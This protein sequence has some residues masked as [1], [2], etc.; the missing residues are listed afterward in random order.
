MKR[1]Y[2]RK[3]KP[4]YSTEYKLMY[5]LKTDPATWLLKCTCK[6]E[7]EAKKFVNILENVS[8]RYEQLKVE[9]VTICEIV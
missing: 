6:T 2:N 8:D 9:Q 1:K 4:V 3:P 7:T 5:T